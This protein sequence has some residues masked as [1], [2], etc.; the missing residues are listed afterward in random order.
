MKLNAKFVSRF[1]TVIFALFL[2]LS[3]FT[4]FAPV[5]VYAAEQREITV[6][7]WEDYIDLGYDD[8]SE[9]SEY[10]IEKYGVEALETSILDV[11]EEQTGIKVNYYSFATNEEMYNELIKD[12]TA[13]DLICPSEY[14][15]LKMIDEDL[16]KAF[17]MPQNYIDYGSE[18]IKDVFDKLDLNTD[19]GKTYAIGYMWGTMGFIY[20]AEKY[21]EE[22]F[23]HWAS[24]YNPEFK[25]K[26]TIKDSLR[27]SYI[28]GVGVVYEQELMNLKADFNNGLITEDEYSDKIFEIFNRTDEDTVKAVGEKI[29]DMKSNLYGFE[30]DAGKSDL[31]TGKVDVNFAWSG[32]AVYTMLEGDKVDESFGYAVPEE[33]SNV[34]FDGFVMTK[35]ANEELSREFLNFLCDPYYAVRNM[36]YIGYTSS[37]AGDE[38]FEYVQDNFGITEDDDSPVKTFDLSYF[39]G[40]GDYTVDAGFYARHLYAQYADQETILRCAVMDNFQAEDLI[41][42][43]EMWNEV[44]LIT[45]SHLTIGLIIGAIVLLIALAVIYKYRDSKIFKFKEKDKKIKEGYKEV[46]RETIY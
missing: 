6:F 29:I 28:M 7:S 26:I 16:I 36:D 11:F 8:A 35:D 43:N 2:S 40:E 17:E 41:R 37:I 9:A 32:D 24:V 14:M 38:V 20:N 21:T 31:L 27:D 34:W 30:V 5:S 13:V 25:G 46:K 45:F 12:P 10:M 23:K 42:I 15:I 19:D 4:A 1:L 33:G 44:K 3:S 22:D 39:F 18:Y